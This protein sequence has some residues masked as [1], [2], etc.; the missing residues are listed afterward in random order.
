MRTILKWIGI[1]LAAL[2]GLA[3]VAALGVYVASEAALAQIY[4]RREINVAAATDPAAL[5]RGRYLAEHVS[6]CVDCHGENLGGG[7]VVDDPALGRI[8]APNLTMGQAGQGREL[9][10]ADL[11]RVLRTG[12]KPDGRS[13]LVMPSDD[14]QHLNDADLAALIAYV[15]GAAPV[16]G[17]PA[18]NEMRAL[19]RFLLATGQL[20]IKIADR[21][22]PMQPAP[23][24]IP[25]GVTPE[26][27]HY[28]ANIAGCTGCH[29]PGLSGGPIPGAPPDWP[30]AA[31][32]TVGGVIKG[33]S[34]AE[35]L[36]TIRTG[37]DRSGHPLN[38]EMPWRRYAGM[39]DD[40]LRAIWAFLQSMPARESGSR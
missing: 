1:G 37:V 7:I 14:Y 18:T 34:E 11:A 3:I 19:G 20:P 27:G 26:Y 33:W 24:A 36:S 10:D 13:A 16:D 23:A 40:D 6:V 17:Q 38:E 35:F 32:I 2:L 31:N 28:L 25:A 21:I 39:S 22:D 5:A 8:V 29:G 9:S 12:V 4:P 30:R 15:R